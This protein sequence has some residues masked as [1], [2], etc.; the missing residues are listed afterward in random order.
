MSSNFGGQVSKVKVCS[1]KKTTKCSIFSGAVIWGVV[2]WDLACIV[3]ICMFGKTSLA[4]HAW[5]WAMPLHPSVN[6]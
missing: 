6:K 3:Y 2:F 5:Q 1:D 4:Q